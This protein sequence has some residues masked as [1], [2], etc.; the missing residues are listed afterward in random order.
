MFPFFK[1]CFMSKTFIISRTDKIGDVI[2]TL[3]MLHVLKE[4]YADSRIVFLGNSYTKDVLQ[5]SSLIDEMIKW[6]EISHL[7]EKQQVKALKKFQANAIIHVFPNKSIAKLAIKAQIP[8]RIGTSHRF[9]HW[10]YCNKLPKVGRK[11]SQLHESQLNI[12][13]LSALNIQ[14]VPSLEQIT[15][16][17]LLDNPPIVHDTVKSF[18]DSSRTNLILHPHSF[19]SAR[20]WSIE[21][22]VRLCKILPAQKYHVIFAGTAKEQEM[23]AP[24]IQQFEKVVTDVGGKL[25]LSQYITLI[26]GCDGLVAASTGPLHIAAALG[27]HA[28][29]IYPPI[30][31]M[32]PGRWAPIGKRVHVFCKKT[33]CSLCRKTNTCA[34]VNSITPQEIA[35]KIQAVFS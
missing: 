35:Q 3:P 8:L 20:E 34:C 29:G 32:H 2:L 13:L 10:L 25:S 6:D 1:V 12:S 5:C 21:N 9:F 18:I 22:Y 28:F 7:T 14:E 26:N 31:P 19:G 23:Y 33:T 30:R 24:Y 4:R 15:Q 17:Q 16:Y 27:K 11:N